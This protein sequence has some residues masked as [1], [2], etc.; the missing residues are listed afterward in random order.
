MGIGVFI[1][2]TSAMYQ[3]RRLFVFLAL[4]GVVRRLMDRLCIQITH[5]TFHWIKGSLATML[6]CFVIMFRDG[7]CKSIAFWPVIGLVSVH[8]LTTLKWSRSGQQPP[9]RPDRLCVRL[10]NCIMSATFYLLLKQVSGYHPNRRADAR[11]PLNRVLSSR[12]CSNFVE[13]PSKS[14][15]KICD[16]LERWPRKDQSQDNDRQWVCSFQNSDARW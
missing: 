15:V 6:G 4:L 7:I 11:N 3:N 10:L 13:V 2:R 1:M 16:S 12:Y 9:Y 5:G 14:W 8:W